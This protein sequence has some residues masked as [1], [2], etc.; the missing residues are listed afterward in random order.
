MTFGSHISAAYI[1]PVISDGRTLSAK[2]AFHYEEPGVW[3][4]GDS[5]HVH[6]PHIK[7]CTDDFT[8]MGWEQ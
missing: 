5:A 4:W 7:L 1:C 6:T 3:T 8:V 2:E